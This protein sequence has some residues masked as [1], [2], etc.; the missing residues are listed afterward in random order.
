MKG[1]KLSQET[2]DGLIR[3]ATKPHAIEEMVMES[4]EHQTYRLDDGRLLRIW[5]AT[6]KVQIGDTTNK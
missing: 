1:K 5:K 2:L 3:A 4:S 6:G